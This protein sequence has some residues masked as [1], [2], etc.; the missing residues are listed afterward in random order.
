MT[1]IL[2]SDT[3]SDRFE[4]R[5]SSEWT[6]T[7]HGLPHTPLTGNRRETMMTK[8]ADALIRKL[9]RLF[10]GPYVIRLHVEN[11]LLIIASLRYSLVTANI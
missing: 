9:V 6:F 2:V 8:Q 3:A 4:F 5:Q 11:P 10:R 1:N 7:P